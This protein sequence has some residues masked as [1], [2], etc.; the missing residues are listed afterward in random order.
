MYRFWGCGQLLCV[1]VYMWWW[2]SCVQLFATPWTIVHQPPLSM[3][4]LRQDYWMRCH[5]LLQG[6]FLTQRPNLLSLVLVSGFVTIEP[7]GKPVTPLLLLLSQFS[8][9]Q[10]CVTP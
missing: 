4:F 1:C 9:V 6:I 2:L 8:R 7:P 3:G 10:L 5:F